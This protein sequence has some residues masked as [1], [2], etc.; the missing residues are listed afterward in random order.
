MGYK[1]ISHNGRSEKLNI[2]D[3]NMKL[4]AIPSLKSIPALGQ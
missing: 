2:T 1:M 3:E 4:Y